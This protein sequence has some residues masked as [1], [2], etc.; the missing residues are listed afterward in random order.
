MK[1]PVGLVTVTLTIAILLAASLLIVTG[2]Q[3]E[4]RANPMR[5]MTPASK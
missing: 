4:D 2:T 1:T 5:V 3:G